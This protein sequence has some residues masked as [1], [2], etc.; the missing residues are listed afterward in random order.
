MILRNCVL[1]GMLL[2][3]SLLIAADVGKLT[4]KVTG[5][6]GTGQ[7]S[8][9][10]LFT[11]TT[12][13]SVNRIMTDNTGSFS[14]EL[15]PG[16]YKVEV[17][18]AQ[19]QKLAMPNTIQ[20]V[21][22]ATAKVN[23][24]L[25]AF[26]DGGPVEVAARAPV[27]QNDTAEVSRAYASRL[28]RELPIMD[29]NPQDL[30]GLM[31]GNTPPDFVAASPIAD[32]QRSRKWNTN[33]MPSEANY[34]LYDGVDNIEPVTG[35]EIHVPP[36]GGVEQ[37]GV[38]TSNYTMEKGRAGGA[39]VNTTSG[40][41]SNRVHGGVF[42]F[43]ANEKLRARNFFNP[44]PGEK[45][46]YISNRFGAH[47]SGPISR[48][49]TFFLASYEGSYLRQSESRFTT[50][51]TEAFRAGDF[52]ALTDIQIF[53]P[54]TGTSTGL[55]RTAFAGNR[56]PANRLNPVALSLLRDLPLPNRPGLE[57]NFVL[58]VPGRN[59]GNRVDA[60]LDHTFN[61]RASVFFRWGYSNFQ[62]A[63]GA[64][65]GPVL[66]TSAESRLLAHNAA[67][68]YTHSFTDRWLMD[69]R[70]SYSRYYQRLRS[71]NAFR[72]AAD[73]GF[74]GIDPRG[75]GIP[76][77][78]IAGVETL[79]SDPRLPAQ[80]VDNNFNL[81]GSGTT[82]F[83]HHRI[84]FGLDA[85]RIRAD[86]YRDPLFGPAGGYSF[87]PGVTL[88]ATGDGF[89]ENSAFP[90]S[91]AAFLLGSPSTAG[92]SFFAGTP[93]YH[94]THAAGWIGDTL[95]P[96]SNVTVEL[97]M[98]YE[99]FSPL[100]ARRPGEAFVYDSATNS[101]Y[102]IGQ[103]FIN[104]RGNIRYDTN[105]WAPRVG[106]AVRL[107]R[108][109]VRGGYG[110]SFWNGL[111]GLHRQ[112]ILSDFPSAQ[113]GIANSFLSAGSL[114]SLPVVP[115]G[116]TDGQIAPNSAVVFSNRDRKTPYTQSYNLTVQFDLGQTTAVDLAYVGNVGRQLPYS[117]E[118][119]AA[120]PGTGAAGLPM[121]SLFNR[122]ASTVE[123]ANGVNSSYNSLQANVTRRF[124]KGLSFT[125]AYTFSKALDHGS[126]MTPLWNSFNRRANYGLAD[127]DRTHMFTL[128]HI[129]ELPFGAGTSRLNEGVIGHI[130]GNWELNGIFRGATGTPF[131]VT[132]D[133]T[134]CACP[135]NGNVADLVSLGTE[136][137][138]FPRLTPFGFFVFVPYQFETFGFAAPAPGTFGN[139]GRNIVRGD[140]F[141]NYDL[142][143]FR[144]FP[145]KEQ[146]KLEFRAEAYN[147]TN[148][149]HFAN[150]IGNLNSANFG[151]SLRTLP[152][153]GQRTLQFAIRFIY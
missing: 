90:N 54:R 74:G 138:F 145:I 13:N 26:S 84:R 17:E 33:G 71:S 3:A 97:G 111:L 98:R 101:L 55:N 120:L 122:T 107:S 140:R 64:L 99:L 81:A 53:D 25:S 117:I 133:P 136:T 116:T 109:V 83:S 121:V 137:A 153:A 15:P 21:A 96:R 149:P 6:D 113:L 37:M 16:S 9:A 139:A 79:G 135:G 148:T 41:G 30:I 24:N 93:S 77:I 43:H 40:P 76:T 87:G 80:N 115:Q 85:L 11:D 39:I 75:D 112:T 65:L 126:A 104:P 28:A 66:G 68:G 10:V 34:R 36:P 134:L 124:T 106:F 45:E 60:R 7:A 86:G 62:T 67:I 151:Q 29:R 144:S 27:A 51:P 23:I 118:R 150:P 147:L 32:P 58:N 8:I 146:L 102:A 88:S 78:R 1:T 19:G 103:G 73:F 12:S 132:V 50:V 48:N 72:S 91:L 141:W 22:G 92:R 38:S 128:S 125:A 18:S 61:D 56:I 4:G 152:F 130:I 49:H 94:A 114:S 129:W 35:V 47:I 142:S 14:I 89:G 57:N 127:W 131:N 69:L 2:F 82:Q 143:V 100:E 95:H 123:L 31:A 42:A 20:L 63:E 119:N 108:V 70:L 5:R 59:D 52:S 105:N 46:H 110:I 44:S